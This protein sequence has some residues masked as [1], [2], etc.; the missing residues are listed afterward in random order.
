[1]DYILSGSHCS[2]Y[3]KTFI[4]AFGGGGY[5]CLFGFF[6]FGLSFEFVLWRR[7][8]W[9]RVNMEAWEDGCDLDA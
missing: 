6:F 9:Q 1:M 5:F 4:I 3:T 7:L 8:Q 2:F